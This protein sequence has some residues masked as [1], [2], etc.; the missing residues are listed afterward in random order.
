MSVYLPIAEMA[1]NVLVVVGLGGLIGIV[2]GG[3][4]VGG[5][6]LLT[7]VLLFIRGPAPVAVAT[8]SNQIVAA[9][10]SGALAHWRRGNVDVPMALVL[11]CGGLVGG[12][13]GV[14]LFGVLRRLGHIDLVVSLTYVVLLGSLGLLM[15]Q[16]SIRT[17]LR[18]AR[19]GGKPRR[20]HQHNW[21]HGL[22]FKMR[23]R[24]S[25]L[26]ISALLPLSLGLAVGLMTALMGL[27]AAFY[28]VP[29]MIY[30]LGMPTAMVVGCSLLQIVFVAGAVPFLQAWQNR[31]VDVL[32]AFLLII[33]GVVGAQVGTRLGSRLRG[34]QLRGLLAVTVLVVCLKLAIDL[35]I[36]PDDRY[37]IS[38]LLL[39]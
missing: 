38:L 31:A 25:R 21:L 11:L 20:L 16:E 30:L 6:L 5:G 32:L 24:T 12:G 39:T 13:F 18:L 36:T 9:S 35:T 4:G 28:R 27:A 7:P 1:V 10:F 37:S 14:W 15:L 34:E 8:G 22:P 23:F 2:S 33:G 17:Y 26:Y 3:F 29:A 19:A